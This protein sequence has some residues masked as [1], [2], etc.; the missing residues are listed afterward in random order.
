MYTS[1]P[2]KI[3]MHNSS[4]RAKLREKLLRVNER[5]KSKAQAEAERMGLQYASF[6]RWGKEDPQTGKI[7]VTHVADDSGRLVPYD[8]VAHDPSDPEQEIGGPDTHVNTAPD[9]VAQRATQ[10]TGE[11]HV[12]HK[13]ANT[14]LPGLIKNLM[15]KNPNSNVIIEPSPD[16]FKLRIAT[17]ATGESRQTSI[18]VGPLTITPSEGTATLGNEPFQ[19]SRIESKLLT[20]LAGNQNKLINRAQLLDKVWGASPDVAT[21]TVDMHISRLKKR[22]GQAGNMIQTVHGMGYRIVPPKEETGGFK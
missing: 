19:L 3:P 20:Y 12:S 4:I 18:K 11:Y 7:K 2:I 14:E 21:R 9:D 22:L 16:G 1:M 8:P 13:D 5:M 6:G 15:Q 10:D 17:N